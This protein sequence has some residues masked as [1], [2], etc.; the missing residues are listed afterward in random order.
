M[1]NI[2]RRP[3]D[4]FFFFLCHSRPHPSP[5]RIAEAQ[6]QIL[7]PI[8]L[9]FGELILLRDS[10]KRGICQLQQLSSASSHFQFYDSTLCSSSSSS[11]SSYSSSYSSPPIAGVSQSDS[12]I[13]NVWP[14]AA[15][16]SAYVPRHHHQLR[17]LHPAISL[18]KY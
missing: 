14:A 18:S 16:L 4:I 9:D 10:S 11:S 2:R 5:L 8:A 13:H 15:V 3:G 6:R 17:Q 7:G 1:L 12:S